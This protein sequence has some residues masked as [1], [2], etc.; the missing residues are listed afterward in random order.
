MIEEHLKLLGTTMQD[1]VTGIKGMVDSVCFDAYGCVQASLREPVKKDGTLA[2]GSWFDI[3]RL[4][5]SGKR[6]MAAPPHFLTPPGKENGA[7][8]KPAFSSL[9]S[10]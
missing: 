1:V 10:R 2:P 6:I 3:K 4:K 7:A 8:D 5:P 9:P